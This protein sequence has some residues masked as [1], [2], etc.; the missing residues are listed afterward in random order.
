MDSLNTIVQ[1]VDFAFY[2]IIGISV[3]LLVGIT[4]VMI[5]YAFKYSR[6]KNKVATQIDGSTKLEILWTVI[7]TI[8]VLAM[9]WVGYVGYTPMRE[10]PEDAMEVTATGRMWSWSFEYEN[11]L[12][13]DRLVVP[14][15]QAVKLN[16]RSVDVNHSL[17]IPAYRI[18]ED[19]I[20]GI[21]NKMWVNPDRLGS[22]DI[23]CAE[24]C[25]TRHSYMITQMDVV[26][27]DEFEE[28]YAEGT[29]L[30]ESD[31]PA[32]AGF[33]L[34]KANG[35]VACHSTDGSKIIASSF[36]G[37]FGA[38]RTIQVDGEEKEIVVDEAYIKRSI[39]DPK[40]EIVVGFTPVMP[41]YKGQ[42]SDE[43]V[44]KIIAYIKT[45]ND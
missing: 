32:I 42:I 34:I 14:L 25:G 11:G 20:P 8:L 33:E 44:D 15:N 29:A 5:F 2:F 12:K 6:K 3:I 41:E 36:K 16:L 40:A 37:L 27:Q 26:N 24:Y 38:K 21:N 30:K 4:T 17:Y 9:F 23:Y 22:F 10:I 7:P 18:K 39:L 43:D 45:L 35:C 1:K 28:W 13:S 19:V 31:D